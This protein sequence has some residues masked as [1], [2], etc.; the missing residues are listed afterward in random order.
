MYKWG[1]R[2]S[3]E[4]KM[5]ELKEEVKE[6]V[7]ETVND[8]KR[9]DKKPL[10]IA[11]AAGI[12]VVIL[13]VILA[14]SCGRKDNKPAE[15]TAGEVETITL[16][17]TLSDASSEE[18]TTTGDNESNSIADDTTV[19][20]K[21]TEEATADEAI[22]GTIENTSEKENSDKETDK[23]D[24][25]DKETVDKTTAE[26]TTEKD[27]SVDETTAK[28]AAT[29]VE[30]TT[31]KPA[32]PN[33]TETGTPYANHGKLTVSGA[34][35]LDKNGNI[36]QL[37][38]VSTHGIQWF[39][40]YVNFDAFKTMR[41][42]WGINVV[43]LA[44]YTH[45]GG[46]CNGANK[47]TMKAL[48]DKGVQAATELGLYVIIDW[49][50]LNE[51]YPSTYQSEAIQFFNEM[52]QKY[53]SYGNVIYEICN[54]PNSGP[55]WADV[56]KYAETIIPV[57]RKNCDNIIIVGTPTWSQDVDQAAANP[58]KGQ[59]NIM[60]ALHFYAA[61]HKDY[62]WNRMVAAINAGLPVF[63][64]EYGICDASGNG[65]YDV[66]SAN[67]WMALMD[68]YHISSCIWNLANKNESSSLIVSSCNK[69]SGWNLNELSG[70]GQWFVNM[71]KGSTS[72]LGTT[73]P[74]QP[75][76]TQPAPQPT[77]PPQTQPPAPTTQAA[78]Q[79]TGS[80]CT[81]TVNNGNGW[82]GH[83]QYDIQI[84]NGGSAPV[85]GWKLVLTFNSEVG[86]ESSW[87]GNFAVSGKT[88]TVTADQDWNQ[89]IAAGADITSGVIITFTGSASLVSAE[90]K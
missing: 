58:V 63:V 44:M 32:A 16:D 5:D 73:T 4:K 49:H 27:T 24:S 65:G 77:Q 47:D 52:S 75:Q 15:T 41:D 71:L 67:T 85:T 82:D 7:S 8:E 11:F 86:V 46:Y 80:N 68:Q 56:K 57:I 59:I 6:Q 45:E 21:E 90:L 69:T 17:V 22:T 76:Q 9:S 30:P 66:N 36:Y 18:K 64:S 2:M 83:A 34:N 31:A 61:T 10:I 62:L 88:I 14:V 42:E 79:A 48:I 84:K 81:V 39:P 53:A 38:G 78:V 26:K 19:A 55:S 3:D 28:P 13:A 12:A 74:S 89:T 87:N 54:E 20:D 25:T 1:R 72:G 37:K 43:R 40:Q 51:K 70:E 29:T 50:V 35:M 60:Y 23:G 33:K